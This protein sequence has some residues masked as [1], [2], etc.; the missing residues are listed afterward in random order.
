MQKW[1]GALPLLVL[2]AC[3]AVAGSPTPVRVPADY[4]P[5]VSLAPLVDAVE[6]AVVNVYTI[7]TQRMSDPRLQMFGLPS[8]R[9]VQGQ[10]SGFVI[11]ADGFVLTNNHV[12]DGAK[13]LKVRFADGVEYPARVVGSD[14]GSDVALLKIDGEKSFSYLELGGKE[15]RV[16]DWVVAVG[17][18]LGLGHTVT[19]G[20]VSGM[21]RNIPE[22]PLEEFIQTDASINPGNSGGPLIGV[23]GKVLGMN[24]AIVAGANT[25]GFAIPATHIAEI[26]PQL[27]DKGRVARGYM[28]V[29]MASIPEVAQKALGKGVLIESVVGGGP[30]DKAGMKAGDVVVRVAGQEIEDQSDMLRT[31]AGTPPGKKVEV[32][33]MRQGKE[34]AL[35]VELAERPGKQESEEKEE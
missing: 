35:Q 23:D 12:V 14:S 1:L 29:Q 28:G 13:D 25:V 32:V 30:A 33:V 21:G 27:R 18:P 31:V 3:S 15:P 26:L 19:A 22:L 11:S 20:I 34:K 16:G 4:N 2:T 8:E 17:N 10:G 6:P 9:T 24:T 7:S 5:M